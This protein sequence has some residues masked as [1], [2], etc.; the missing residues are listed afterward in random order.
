MAGYGQPPTARE[1]QAAESVNPGSQL[2][3]GMKAAAA[4]T[5]FVAAKEKE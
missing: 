3:S 4:F 1:Q 2:G 5:K